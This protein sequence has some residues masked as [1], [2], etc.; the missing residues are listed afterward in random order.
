MNE[1]TSALR[2]L[3]LVSTLSLA[4]ATS[5]CE[6]VVGGTRPATATGGSADSAP[7]WGSAGGTAAPMN[8][9][10][11]SA[12][13]EQCRGV[14]PD[15]G[16]GEL[17]RLTKDEYNATIAALLKNSSAPATEFL[18]DAQ[19]GLFPTNAGVAVP[20]AQLD[21]YRAAAETLAK[22]SV[23]N[24]QQLVP[25]AQGTAI[26]E[27][28]AAQFIG[29]FGA[30]AYRRPMTTDEVARYAA[31]FTAGVA[32]GSSAD[33]IR[34]VISA[35]LQSAHFL[36]HLEQPTAS[37]KDG[38]VALNEHELA[39]KLA[40]F[41]TSGPPDGELMQAAARG[42]VKASLATH[43]QRLLATPAARVTIERLHTHLLGLDRTEQL[44]KSPEV[45]PFFTPQLATAMKA[46]AGR[47]AASVIFDG[48]HTLRSL[49]KGS[50]SVLEP[51]LAPLYGL[52]ETEANGLVQLPNRS[53]ILTLP[54]V[55]ATNAHP[56]QSSP[57]R[58]GKF[59]RVN[60]LCQS[61][62]PPP[63]N[64]DINPPSPDP[65][66]STRDRF[67][68]HRSEPA[69]AGCHTLLDP[70]GFGFEAYDAVGRYRTTDGQFP[71]DDSGEFA[72]E[73]T[74]VAGSFKGVAE[75]ADKLLAAPELSGC[76]TSQ[77][78][79]FAMARSISDRDTCSL[80]HVRE[81]FNAAGGDLQQLILSLV[82]SY[83]FSQRRAE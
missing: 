26:D 33:G 38:V 9:D 14:A 25:C 10:V 69:C 78:A 23:E 48:D 57:I 53:G 21:K 76:M 32:V 39:S 36:Y 77:W 41:I 54:A 49:L 58:R 60:L 80:V 71:V 74:S 61:L 45:A 65:G 35:F 46:E 50:F 70:L 56:D 40:Y 6:G 42:E 4:L 59:V 73:P 22:T 19:V 82:Q 51:A 17:R 34:L 66:L 20:E 28:C 43:A 62:P 30:H 8:V 29:S 24:L 3:L 13:P 37:A 44:K 72:G 27:A 16:I 63:D 68:A 64:A 75:L 12:T 83:T 52:S 1:S 18:P 55:M 31:L 2:P 7:G 79:T 5:A 11:V 15:V 81:Q 67:A 47:F